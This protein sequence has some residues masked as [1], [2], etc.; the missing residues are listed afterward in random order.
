MNV[1]ARQLSEPDFVARLEGLLGE[2]PRNALTLE[3]TE[4]LLIDDPRR[5][6]Q[7]LASIDDLGVRLALDDFGT[8]YS[9]LSYLSTLPIHQLKIDRS[10]IAKLGDGPEHDT[11]VS[12]II[13]LAQGLGLQVVAEGIET[14]TQARRLTELGCRLAQ[15]FHFGRPQQ[16]NR[17]SLTGTGAAAVAVVM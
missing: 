15:G 14:E 3:I 11:L 10:F 7:T 12:G 9:N 6:A 16:W 1:S 5:A 17:A 2:V 4:S 13:H 8:G